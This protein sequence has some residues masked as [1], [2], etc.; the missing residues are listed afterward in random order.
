MTLPQLFQIAFSIA[1]IP[2]KLEGQGDHLNAASIR[3]TQRNRGYY[4]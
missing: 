3:L 2:L 1:P 4:L